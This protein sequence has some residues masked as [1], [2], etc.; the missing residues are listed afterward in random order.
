MSITSSFRRSAITFQVRKRI[1]QFA[2]LLRDHLPDDFIAP[3]P[4]A[5][6]AYGDVNAVDHHHMEIVEYVLSR[7]LLL[8]VAVGAF[9]TCPRLC[10][11]AM[12]FPWFGLLSPFILIYENV[13]KQTM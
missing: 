10:W 12:S 1:L 6:T 2:I 8:S 7:H 9:S 3:P 5:I 4:R 13:E 11:F